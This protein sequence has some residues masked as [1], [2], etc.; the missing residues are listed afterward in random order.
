MVDVAVASK[1]NACCCGGVSSTKEC[2]G[3][4]AIGVSVVGCA[5]CGALKR[6]G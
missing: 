2:T 5:D 4:S 1:S 6:L 3:L